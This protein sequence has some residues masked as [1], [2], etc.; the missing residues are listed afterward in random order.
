MLQKVERLLTR[1]SS[2][3]DIES[4]ILLNGIADQKAEMNFHFILAVI[5]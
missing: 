1:E 3:I 4:Q 2:R 5:R